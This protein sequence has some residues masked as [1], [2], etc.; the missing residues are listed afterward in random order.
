MGAIAL[1][2]MGCPFDDPKSPKW[3][4]LGRVAYTTSSFS[5]SRGDRYHAGV[6]YST[7]ME[8][9]WPVQAPE[10]GHVMELRQTPFA[11]GRNLVFKGNSGHIWV[12][13]HLSGFIPWLD[14][15]F[16]AQKI[17]GKTNDLTWKPTGNAGKLIKEY[18]TIAYSGSTGIGNPHL[19]MEMRDASN[20]VVE[21][22]CERA[23][24]CTDTLP[25]MLMGA[26]VWDAAPGNAQVSIT[27]ADELAKGCLEVDPAY[28]DPRVAFKIVD[29]SR[30]PLENP[31]NVE[32]ISLRFGSNQ[33]FHKEYEKQTFGKMARIREELLWSERA[34]TAGDWHIMARGIEPNSNIE[35]ADVKKISDILRAGTQATAHKRKTQVLKLELMDFVYNPSRF[36]L[37]PSP[38]C[39]SASDSFVPKL[40]KLQDSVLFT[41][42]ARPWI[43][44]SQCKQGA[45][46]QL[47]DS[48]GATINDSICQQFSNT[49]QPLAMLTTKWPAART[50]VLNLPNKTVRTIHILPLPPKAN[51]PIT[52]STAGV[53]M[54]LVPFPTPFAN[55]LAW[56][57]RDSI[58][59]SIPGK[60]AGFE[61]H[62]K[63]LHILGDVHTCITPQ[64]KQDKAARLYYLGETTRRWF[65]FSKQSKEADSTLCTQADEIRD[66]GIFVDT[67]APQL[68]TPRDT[69][70]FLAGK[71]MPALRIPVLEQWAGIPDGNAIQAFVGDTWIPIEFDSDPSEIVID[72]R[73]LKA[74]KPLRIDIHDEAGNKS[75]RTYSF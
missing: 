14:T 73:Y 35:A 6:D 5:E 7:N 42:L 64:L 15:A 69:T 27:S 61:I 30:T 50:L 38:S 71:R 13:A 56:E 8:E 59:D 47:L 62:P 48:V 1:P 24:A 22:P 31:M 41:F 46:L 74:G 4:P 72:K 67:T 32:D 3:N 2:V 11:Y 66:L 63:G 33:V 55:V 52:W 29:Y 60:H 40:T 70:T 12:F 37:T 23:V 10:D 36:H 43:N 28:K 57:H 58:K 45:H 17:H 19:H 34:D 65:Y 39:K 44:L 75:S 68:G 25:P 53:K 49:A 51:H 26:A 9:G 16:E 18:D 54:T 21:N 20:Q